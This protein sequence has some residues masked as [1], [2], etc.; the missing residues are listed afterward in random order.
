G[1]DELLGKQDGE[2]S[3]KTT[4]IQSRITKLDADIAA[5]AE[6]IGAVPIAELKN[7]LAVMETKRQQTKAELDA[8]N[9]TMLS[10]STPPAF[11][12]IKAVFRRLRTYP[13]IKLERGPSGHFEGPDID[14]VWDEHWEQID[15]AVAKLDKYKEAIAKTL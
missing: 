4:A 15:E 11:M 3:A 8:L 1:P 5:A 6:L 7:K 2:H 12:D 10:V 9:H 14:E 13:V